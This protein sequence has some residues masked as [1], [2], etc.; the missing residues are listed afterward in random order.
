MEQRKRGRAKSSPIWFMPDAE[1][2]VLLAKAGTLGDV[3]RAFGLVNKGRNSNTLKARLEASGL[4]YS[5]IPMGIGANAGR[6]FVRTDVTPLQQILVEGSS[7]ARGHLKRRLLASGLLRNECYKCE[8]PPFWQGEPL[9]L[10]MDHINGIPDDNRIHNLRML[11]PNCNSQTPTFTGRR[12]RKPGSRT[13]GGFLRK[14]PLRPRLEIE[15]RYV[16]GRDGV[17]YDLLE[18]SREMSNLAMSKLVGI[19]D[20][21]IAKR[22][23]KLKARTELLVRGAGYDPASADSKA[24]V[25]TT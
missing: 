6:R 13:S 2:S 15:H 8:Q 4:D 24:A 21:A 23:K 9:V 18:M 22:L 7:Y 17:R 5:H 10:V 20:V 1:L 14:H 19:S 11:C 25:L 12:H 3:L 16:E